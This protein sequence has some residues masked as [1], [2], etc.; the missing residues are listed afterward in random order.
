MLRF[1]VMRGT[2]AR[3][4]KGAQEPFKVCDVVGMLNKCTNETNDIA[5]SDNEKPKKWRRKK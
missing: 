1:L 3:Y 5:T 2:R 4:L